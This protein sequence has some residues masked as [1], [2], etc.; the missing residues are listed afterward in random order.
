MTV[1]DEVKSSASQWLKANLDKNYYY[2]RFRYSLLSYDIG[3]DTRGV[4]VHTTAGTGLA[5]LNNP[6]AYGN[7]YLRIH[8]VEDD[9]SS[10]LDALRPNLNSTSS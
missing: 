7:M 9:T 10:V 8:G 1:I 5:A 6:L 4:G 2:L 3:M